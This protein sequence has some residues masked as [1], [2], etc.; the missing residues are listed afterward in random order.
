MRSISERGELCRQMA[1]GKSRAAGNA[2]AAAQWDAAMREAKE[3]TG[4]LRQF[5]KKEWVHP[6]GVEVLEP[7]GG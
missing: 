2:P 6:D 7:S 1:G 4:V 5:L 3:R